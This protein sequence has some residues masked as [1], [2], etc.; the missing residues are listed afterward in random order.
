MVTLL[1]YSLYGGHVEGTSWLQMFHV[2]VADFSGTGPA[3]IALF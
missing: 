3:R 2:K 1:I